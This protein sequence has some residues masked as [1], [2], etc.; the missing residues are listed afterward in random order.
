MEFRLDSIQICHRLVKLDIFNDIYRDNRHDC[1]NYTEF[2]AIIN[3]C[4]KQV[5]GYI[6]FIITICFLQQWFEKL[7]LHP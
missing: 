6:H 1:G 5:Y 7:F 2:H 4:R 3:V